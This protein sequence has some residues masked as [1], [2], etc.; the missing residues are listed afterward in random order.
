MSYLMSAS[1]SFQKSAHI[2]QQSSAPSSMEHVESSQQLMASLQERL[3]GPDL[4]FHLD[5][6][7]RELKVHSGILTYPVLSCLV[8]YFLCY[9]VL[10]CVVSSR[11][12]IRCVVVSC[13]VFVLCCVVVFSL[14]QP[15]SL[16]YC[17]AARK[18]IPR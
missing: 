2:P 1:G 8:L 4:I 6:K 9:V 5:Q 10:S 12:V 3:L 16:S 14:L 7:M 13:L 11:L 18:Q 15:L 17:C